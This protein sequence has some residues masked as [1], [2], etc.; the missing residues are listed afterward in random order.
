M[1]PGMTVQHARSIALAVVLVGISALAPTPR[2]HAQQTLDELRVL[3][4]QGDADAQFN[5][6]VMYADGEGVAQDDAEA[7]RWFRLAGRPRRRP[8]AVQPRRDV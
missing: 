7:V 4:E 2:L 8:R 3:A 6:G 5:L 1:P